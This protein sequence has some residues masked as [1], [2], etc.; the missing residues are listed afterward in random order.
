MWVIPAKS[1]K[2]IF[3]RVGEAGQALNL[4]KKGFRESSKESEYWGVYDNSFINLYAWG[5]TKITLLEL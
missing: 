4:S 2:G 5:E 1:W 3:F